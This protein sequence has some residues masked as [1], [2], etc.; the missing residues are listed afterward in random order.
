MVQI[1]ANRIKDKKKKIAVL[2]I[3]FNCIS[4]KRL[5]V[6]AD[7]DLFV[8]IWR[9]EYRYSKHLKIYI[10]ITKIIEAY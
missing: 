7:F 10:F 8:D 6:Y 1:Y 4:L 5:S 3:I 9:P 2:K